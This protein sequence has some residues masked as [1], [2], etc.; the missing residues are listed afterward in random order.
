MFSFPNYKPS[1]SAQRNDLSV[2]VPLE[3]G[4]GYEQRFS[5]GFNLTPQEWDLVFTGADDGIDEVD[6]F[7]S[8]RALDN[9]PFFW[10]T[11]E[12]NSLYTWIC[13]SWK[14]E[15]SDYNVSRLSAKFQQRGFTVTIPTNYGWARQL[16]TTSGV[17]YDYEGENVLTDKNGNIYYVM[18]ITI[19]SIRS[20]IAIK[21]SLNGTLIWAKNI[22]KATGFSNSIFT[23]YNQSWFAR[24][25]PQGLVIVAGQNSSTTLNNL[26]ACNKVICLN[27][28][29]GSLRW[30]K[31]VTSQGISAMGH[32]FASVSINDKSGH[33]YISS[34][35][36]EG[37]SGFNIITLDSNGDVTG[38]I[39]SNFYG[40]IIFT[41]NGGQSLPN[42]SVAIV[43]SYVRPGPNGPYYGPSNRGG[44]Y[45]IL[46]ASGSVQQSVRIVGESLSSDYFAFQY[47]PL[48]TVLS[49]S[50]ILWTGE[51]GI[52]EFSSDMSSI[53]SYKN[54]GAIDISERPDGSFAALCPQ[55]IAENPQWNQLSPVNWCSASLKILN[56]SRTQ[57]T[58]V[59]ELAVGD[60]PY[61][62]LRMD[63]A[64]SNI[65]RYV[66]VANNTKTIVS[67][68]PYIDYW[69][70]EVS[71]LGYLKMMTLSTNL[72]RNTESITFPSITNPNFSYSSAQFLISDYSSSIVITDFTDAWTSYSFNP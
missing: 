40:S 27:P 57:I 16:S 35:F 10:T 56:S 72:P 23:A 52:I 51:K 20:I 31:A 5:F 34:I 36:Q 62:S 71:P 13:K 21:Y 33:T 4:D 1:Y 6:S 19:N 67:I 39:N 12:N 38:N 66:F 70:T 22:N 37:N 44:Y 11:P 46:T 8:A 18:K 43:G 58:A 2:T 3:F 15:K 48:G 28:E 7:L 42:G 30:A 14:K 41:L 29:N 25:G 9:E 32:L 26:S 64:T 59:K 63:G 61:V 55:F 45:I 47:C 60:N 65:D 53:I 54:I 68:D 50:N 17:A 49:N 69:R 24:I